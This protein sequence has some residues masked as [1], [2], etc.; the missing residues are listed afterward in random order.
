MVVLGL[1]GWALAGLVDSKVTD[2][3]MDGTFSTKVA[4]LDGRINE[5]RAEQDIRWQEILRRLE[6]IES[7]LDRE[8]V[9]RSTEAK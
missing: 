5:V 2:G 9:A 1:G 7:K 8:R 3:K 6:R 4:R